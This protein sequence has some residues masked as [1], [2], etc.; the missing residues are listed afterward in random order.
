MKGKSFSI[1]FGMIFKR[2][3]CHKCGATL[4]KEKTHRIVSKDDRDYY[5]YHDYG[6]FPRYDYDVYDYQFKCPNCQRRISYDEQLV[7]EV[8]QKKTKQKIVSSN[9]VKD[10]YS[11]AKTTL[12]KRVLLRNILIPIISSLLIVYILYLAE[13]SN[14]NNGLLI[15][16]IIF[17]VIVFTFIISAVKQYNGSAKLRRNQSYSYEHEFLMK[18]LHAYCTCNRNLIENSNKC[19]CFHCGK[20]FEKD[21]IK[22]YID[23]GVTAL[24]PDCGVDSVIPDSVDEEINKEVIND[25]N[26]YW[27]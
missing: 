24:C 27:F 16:G 2:Y 3:H 5:R 12:N 4:K 17:V 6:S 9:E 23:N 11:K 13:F 8:I 21:D 18:K 14:Q 19:Y 20:I 15:V 26:Q 22:E 1:P 25:M 10:N 7:V